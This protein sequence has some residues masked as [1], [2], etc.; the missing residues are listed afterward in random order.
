M[1]TQWQEVNLCEREEKPWNKKRRFLLPS[2]EVPKRF[3]TIAGNKKSLIRTM[4]F[5][6]EWGEKRMESGKSVTGWKIE[7]QKI[8]ES[9][10][11][12]QG[13]MSAEGNILKHHSADVQSIFYYNR[14][15]FTF[16]RDLI[17]FKSSSGND[18]WSFLFDSFQ[19]SWE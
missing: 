4:V 7:W 9:N 2:M 8:P 1:T 16:S 10:F 5:K 15:I 11:K 14:I 3:I 12:S 17:T 19:Y 18:R 13:L 6:V